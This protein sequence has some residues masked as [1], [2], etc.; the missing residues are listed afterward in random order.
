MTTLAESFLADLE[1]LSDDEREEST[2]LR[3]D[4]TQDDDENCPGEGTN[5]VREDDTTPP[6]QTNNYD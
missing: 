4:K 5:E 3:T 1:E 2:T 6:I